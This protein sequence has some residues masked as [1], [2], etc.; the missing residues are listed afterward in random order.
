MNRQMEKAPTMGK[1]VRASDKKRM[2]EYVY[3]DSERPVN[4]ARRVRWLIRD[5]K[6]RRV[7]VATYEGLLALLREGLLEGRSRSCLSR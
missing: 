4:A 5:G 6:G 1:I 3:T 2:T 7:V